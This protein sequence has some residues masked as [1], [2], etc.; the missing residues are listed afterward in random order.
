MG[1]SYLEHVSDIGIL[2]YGDSMEDAFRSGAEALLN[3]VFDL[4]TIG[5]DIAVPIEAR[6]PEPE[7]LFVEALNELIS[8]LDRDGL[9][10][11]G[12]RDVRIFEGTGGFSMSAVAY[13]ESFS[14]DLHTVKCEVKG[15]TYS[16][17]SYELKD[18][19]HTFTCVVDV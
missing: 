15:A 7:L 3:I 12:I 2:A 9:A 8:V 11:K 13:G 14:A 17:L 16:G 19:K 6:A 4:D 18:G 5:T 1:Y 10:L